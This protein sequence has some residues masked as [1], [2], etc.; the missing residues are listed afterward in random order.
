MDLD[1]ADILAFQN[2]IQRQ[3]AHKQ[4]QMIAYDYPDTMLDI[5]SHST[6]FARIKVT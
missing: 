5:Y 6:T 1:I 3:A 4:S 2:Q